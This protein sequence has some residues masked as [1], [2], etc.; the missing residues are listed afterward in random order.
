MRKYSILVSIL[1][2]Q[3]LIFS[4]IPT[5]ERKALIDFYVNTNGPSWS[6]CKWDTTLSPNNWYGV[7]IENNHVTALKFGYKTIKGSIPATLSQLDSLKSIN[8]S[9]NPMK[10]GLPSSLFSLKKL[11]ELNLSSC[12]SLNGLIPKEIGLATNLKVLNLYGNKLTGPIPKEISNLKKLETLILSYN[13]FADTI[14][15]YLSELS[16]LKHLNISRNRFIGPFPKALTRL[17]SLQRLDI[18]SNQLK[19]VLP[20]EIGDF[21]NLKFLDV[22]VNDFNGALPK[23]LGKLSKIEVLSMSQNEFSGSIPKELGNLK[24]LT[25][26]GLSWN[27]L[28]GTLPEELGGMD[29]LS[30]LVLDVNKLEGGIPA[31]FKNLKRLRAVFILNNQLS[32]SIPDLTQ[33]ANLR[34]FYIA[35]NQF[36]FG[37]FEN[38]IGKF[39]S[40]D[41]IFPYS[42]Q[43]L[44]IATLDTFVVEGKDFNRAVKV[45]GQANHYQWFFGND[46]LKGATSDHLTLKNVAPNMAGYYF[47]KVTSDLV[48]NMISQGA[49]VYLKVIPRCPEIIS[50]ILVD[51]IKSSSDTIK[52]EYLPNVYSYNIKMGYSPTSGE[53]YDGFKVYNPTHSIVV[54]N[55][56]PNSVVYLRIT[57][58]Y[59]QDI[60]NNDC[61]VYSLKV[62]DALSGISS[63]TIDQ[64]SFMVYPNPAS[65]TLNVVGMSEEAPY[66]V[67]NHLGQELFSGIGNTVTLTGLK[68][69]NYLIRINNTFRPFMVED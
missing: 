8:L 64:D 22:Q 28:T 44:G 60:A 14:P 25:D 36:H 6:C 3:S 67:Y 24:K 43:G 18:G 21:K 2:F 69:G 68:A 63:E 59:Q 56:Q 54:K 30:T 37:D 33:N 53:I 23:E 58:S 42:N 16:Q 55:L 12:D 66:R 10:G 65:N 41:I 20:P 27:D 50:S 34:F 4:Q 48:P 31:S 5:K 39:V 45:R 62:K 32:G 52:W 26:L 9:S 57:P 38:Y 47:L 61:Q 46:T 49:Y 7:T 29:S 13:L 35:N 17:D 19:G 51:S 40:P 11:E 1:I 15:A